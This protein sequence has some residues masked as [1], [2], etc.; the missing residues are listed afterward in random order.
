MPLVLRTN[1]AA[2]IAM[3]SVGSASRR[4]GNQTQKLATGERLNS[5]ADG[6]AALGV[7]VPAPPTFATCHATNGARSRGE[8]V[9]SRVRSRTKTP[10]HHTT[11]GRQEQCSS[12]TIQGPLWSAARPLSRRTRTPKTPVTR[13]GI[14]QK[15]TRNPVKFT[16]CQSG[17]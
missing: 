5:A 2:A 14:T 17:P 6:A 3:R 8:C 16:F 4:V 13:P 9:M 7:T 11:I 10:F 1:R 15:A 12:R